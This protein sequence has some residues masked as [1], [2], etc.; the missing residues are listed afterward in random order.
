MERRPTVGSLI[1]I[2][3]VATLLNACAMGATRSPSSLQ[4]DVTTILPPAATSE[5]EKVFRRALADDLALGNQFGVVTD[6]LNLADTYRS[7]RVDIA[8]A[9]FE[10]ALALSRAVDY[11]AGVS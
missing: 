6:L 5:R 10:K 3:F 8:A 4:S 1:A 11:Q 7:T 9:L 2:V